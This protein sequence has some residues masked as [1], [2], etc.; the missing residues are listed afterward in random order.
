MVAERY[1]ISKNY[2]KSILKYQEV[3]RF[4]PDYGFA[5]NGIGYTYLSK[6][7]RKKAMHSWK[8]L[9][10]LMQNDSLLW[11]YENRS[12][13]EG[14]HFYLDKAK[15]N[16]PQFC[17]NPVL[18]SSIEMLVEE[19]SEAIKFLKIAYKYNNEDLPIMLTYPIFRP[20]H[21]NKEFKEIV[22]NVGVTFSN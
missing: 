21:T 11:Y 16:S 4:T 18:I 2:E 3:L 8:E 7:N 10:K 5:L 1:Y 12:F 22:T 6:G 15:L 19:P 17:T 14:L 13:E 9:Q 20:L